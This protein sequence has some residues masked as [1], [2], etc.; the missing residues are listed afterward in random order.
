MKSITINFSKF[1]YLLNFYINELGY[2]RITLMILSCFLISTIELGGLVLLLPFLKIVTEQTFTKDKIAIIGIFFVFFHISRGFLSYRIIRFQTNL[3]AYI[4]RELSDKFMIKA[5]SSRYQ[6]FIDQ[7]PIK[8]ATISYSNST[9]IS[10]V[11]QALTNFVNE[12]LIVLFVFIGFLLINPI[13]FFGFLLFLFFLG[14]LVFKPITKQINYLGKKS[15][16]SE[17][18]RYGFINLIANAIHDIKIMS[19]ENIFT[20]RNLTLVDKHSKLNAKYLAISNTQRIVIEVALISM[21]VISAIIFSLSTLDIKQYAPFII[22]L[23]LIAVRTAPA[24]SRLS[25]SFNTI[26]Y[27]LPYVE[28]YIETLKKLKSYSQLRVKQKTDLPGKLVAKNLSFNYGD[29]LILENCSLEINQG[30]IIAIVGESGSGK[31]TLLDLVSGILP[32]SDGEFYLNNCPFSPFL[33]RKFPSRIGY[34]PQSIAI[35]NDSISFNISLTN[36]PDK[37]LLEKSIA[38]ANLTKFINSLSKGIDTYIGDGGQGLSGGQRQ[39]IGIARAIYRNPYL[40]ILDEI[41][42]SLDE[43]TAKNVMQEILLMKG[44]V[45]MLFVSHDM[46]FIKADKIYKLENK[47]LS[48]VDGKF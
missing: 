7:S 44:E 11:F 4:N 5:L 16:E 3:G 12:F 17:L 41:T 43:V 10:I 27:S 13:L 22:T 35:L 47:T 19:L 36:N 26:Q 23:G 24:L 45:S 30:E 14:I 25:A 28:L 8:I 20:Q 46:R 32:Q 37:R 38:K 18:K 40:L 2:K 34:V 48:L 39:R 29:K 6:L 15:Q 21:V 42:S 33:S 31:S 1:L 9:H